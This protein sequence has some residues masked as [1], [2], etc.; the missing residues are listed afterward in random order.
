V[1]SNKTMMSLCQALGTLLS[2]GVQIDRAL[3][4]TADQTGSARVRAALL[5]AAE[6]IKSG[7]SLAAALAAQRLFPAMFLSLVE[8][9]EASGSMDRVLSEMSRVYELQHKLWR[10]FLGAITLPVLQYCMAVIV[11]GLVRYITAMLSGT[12]SVSILVAV[13]VLLLGYGV[14][15]ALVLAYVFL[16]KPIGAHRI[17]HELVLHVPVLGGVARTFALARLSLVLHLMYEAGV[18][19]DEALQRAFRG[20]GNPVFAAQAR[21]VAQAVAGGATLT[22]ALRQTGLFPKEFME[23]VSVAEES[24]RVSERLG[25]M[26]EHYA[27]QTETAMAALTSVAAVLI[28]CC[29]AGFIIYFIFTFFLQYIH[30]ITNVMGG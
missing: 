13:P 11:L 1:P 21:P 29:V 5:R 12:G 28:W 27:H 16:L 24:G 6:L 19:L 23:I 18:G 3:T 10:R 15:V 7:S 2:S 14:P 22:E 25:W 8:A 30:S 20:S 17:V 26:A 9:G 4:V